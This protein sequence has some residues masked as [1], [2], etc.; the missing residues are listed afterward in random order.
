MTHYYYLFFLHSD[1]QLSFN[2]LP[3]KSKDGIIGTWHIRIN[4][5]TFLE[6]AMEELQGEEFDK[7]AKFEYLGEEGVDSGGLLRD[8]FTNFFRLTPLFEDNTLSSDALQLQCGL[9]G[10]IVSYAVVCGHC[11]PQCLHKSVVQFI[12]KKATDI[13]IEDVKNAQ[14]QHFFSLVSFTVY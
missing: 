10:K 7:L 12:L 11:G 4:R 13:D 2:E 14:A 6:N 9:L 5:D 3:D 1:E 8:F